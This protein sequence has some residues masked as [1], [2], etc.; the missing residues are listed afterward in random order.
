MVS[1]AEQ[2]KALQL[3]ERTGPQLDPS[4]LELLNSSHQYGMC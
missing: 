2:R 1:K 4:E 3:V